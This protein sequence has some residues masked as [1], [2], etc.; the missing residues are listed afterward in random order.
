MQGHLQPLPEQKVSLASVIQ[1]FISTFFS[2]SCRPTATKNVKCAI[3]EMP[4]TYL[5]HI[6]LKIEPWVAVTL[7]YVLDS[8]QKLCPLEN[9]RTAQ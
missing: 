4:N 8:V 6:L 1:A 5:P 7:T 9:I 2:K 3:P